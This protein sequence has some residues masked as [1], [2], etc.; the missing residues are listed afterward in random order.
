MINNNLNATV[1]INY[2]DVRQK[3]LYGDFS[4]SEKCEMIAS[5]QY[6]GADFQNFV[7]A[8]YGAYLGKTTL[9]FVQ[10]ESEESLINMVSASLNLII[11]CL[12]DPIPLSDYID[13]LVGT[14]PTF[15]EFIKN[16]D[17]F[18]KSFMRALVNTFKGNYNERLGMLWY[19]AVSIFA[20]SVDHLLKSKKK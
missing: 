16:T 7:L 1:R 11:T 4:A 3:S 5:L 18:T 12:E 19:K 17:L 15:P 14:H 8:F 6:I 20:L 2:V 13:I 10:K 9:K